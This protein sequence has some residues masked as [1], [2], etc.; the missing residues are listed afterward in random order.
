LISF[1]DL[2]TFKSRIIYLKPVIIGIEFFKNGGNC[3]PAQRVH[4]SWF[5]V[6][7]FLVL[8]AIDIYLLLIREIG[9]TGSGGWKTETW[10]METGNG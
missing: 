10:R 2:I 5:G 7:L 9:V 1:R 6:I 8:G 3:V 4:C